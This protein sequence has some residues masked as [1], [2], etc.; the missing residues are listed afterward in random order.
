M[1]FKK[2]YA[3]SKEH[4]AA[5]AAAQKKRWAKKKTLEQLTKIESPPS[6]SALEA[7]KRLGA[8]SACALCHE[9]ALPGDFPDLGKRCIGTMA[10][11]NC[12]MKKIWTRFLEDFRRKV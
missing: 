2:G 9:Y 6:K 5:I 1:V 7:F 4:R 10:S 3:Q 8:E 12:V 11:R